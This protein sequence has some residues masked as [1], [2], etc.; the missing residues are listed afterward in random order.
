MKQAAML[1]HKKSQPAAP[2]EAAGKS[3]A[4]QPVRPNVYGAKP[5]HA[6][7]GNDHGT[8]HVAAP[9]SHTHA[10]THGVPGERQMEG[11]QAPSVALEQC[12]VISTLGS[13]WKGKFDG[14]AFGSAG[15]G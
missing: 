14:R 5:G 8:R 13:S 15:L 11:M 1:G 7:I 10:T 9:A 12:G 4:L 6:S 3:T 2:K